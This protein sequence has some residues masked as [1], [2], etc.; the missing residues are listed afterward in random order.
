MV[1]VAVAR[2]DDD[3]GPIS[4]IVSTIKAVVMMVMVVMMVVIVLGK[5]DIFVR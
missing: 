5:L 4:V 3:A 2:H 1:M